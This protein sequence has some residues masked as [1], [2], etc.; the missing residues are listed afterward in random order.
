MQNFNLM[1]FSLLNANAHL[2]GWFLRLSLFAARGVIYLVPLCLITYWLFGKVKYR[3][4]LLFA[5]VAATISLVINKMIGFL[6]FQPRPFMVGIGHTY[7]QHAPDSSF[8]SDHVTFMWAVGLSFLFHRG[9]RLTGSTI[10]V[11]AI[12]VGWARVFL[13][14]HFPLDILGAIVIAT[15]SVL[16]LTPAKGFITRQTVPVVEA[17]YRRVFASLITKNIIQK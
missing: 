6:W 2:T 10:L 12:C 5:V 11:L 16:V 9:L 8:P 14:V 7:F 1:I 13:G 15:C 3:E 4:I 17:I